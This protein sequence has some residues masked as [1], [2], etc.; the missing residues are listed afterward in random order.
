MKTCRILFVDDDKDILLMVEQYLQMQGYDVLTVNSG[1]KAL[2]VIKDQ[3]IDIIFSDYKMPEFNGLELLAA[4]KQYKPDI[5]VIIVTGYG[6]ME[7]AIQAMKFGSYDYMQKPFKLD[8]LKLIIDRIIEEKKVKD[9]AALIRKRGRERHKFEG[10]VGISARMQQVYELIEAVGRENP[11]VLIQGESG[12]GKELVARTIHQRSPRRDSAFVPMNCGSATEGIAEE[13]IVQHVT[14]LMQKVHG[15][16]L[17]LDEIAELAP[18][19]RLSILQALEAEQ[20]KSDSTTRVIAATSKELGEVIASGAL[21]KDLF[22]LLNAVVIRMPPLRERREDICLLINH[23]IHQACAKHNRRIIGISP[24]ALDILIGYHW[25]GNLIQL[26][27]VIER[28]L[29]LGVDESIQPADLP[30]EIQTFSTI[31]KMG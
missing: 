15:G 6:S 2:D 7:S 30:A 16:T 14:A 26:Q 20:H 25:P 19:L 21:K 10:L 11:M 3:E 8:H 13:E 28:A 1:L 27:N 18:A 4:V 31:A 9:K 12:T 22:D 29:A 17:Y 24:D 5:E 23:F